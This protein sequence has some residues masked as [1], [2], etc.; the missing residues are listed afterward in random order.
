M[1][2]KS[3]MVVAVVKKI[4]REKLDVSHGVITQWDH[5]IAYVLKVLFLRLTSLLVKVRQK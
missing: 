5:S 3:V 4:F 1:S 2:V